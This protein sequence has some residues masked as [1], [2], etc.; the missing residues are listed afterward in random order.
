MAP[1]D[2]RMNELREE[3]ELARGELDDWVN[4]RLAELTDKRGAHSEAVKQGNGA[5]AA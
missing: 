5:R 4:K 3:L 2:F 1:V